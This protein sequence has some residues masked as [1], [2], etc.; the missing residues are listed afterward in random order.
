[1]KAFVALCLALTLAACAT[2]GGRGLTPGVS[3][4]ADV[5]RVMGPP[6]EKRQ[7][8]GGETW[9]FYPRQPYGRVTFVARL[10]PDGRLVAI[11][12]RLTDEN[13]AKIVPNST[14]VE[15]V[16]DLLGPPYVAGHYARMDRDIWTWHMRRY[17]DPGIPVSLNV[18]MS[19]DGVVREVYIIDE[20]SRNP[21]NFAFGGGMGIGIGL[22]F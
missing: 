6:A 20:S 17:G 11:E 3:S 4:A 15:Q 5:E 21:G 18:Q 7:A 13:V 14:R 9:Y 19:P 16:R 22:G 12:Q 1:M 8:E 2:F 10:A